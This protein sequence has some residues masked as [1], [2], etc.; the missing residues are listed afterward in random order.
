MVRENH[1]SQ[2]LNEILEEA[3]KS[4]STAI[5]M[6]KLNNGTFLEQLTSAIVQ[7]TQTSPYTEM[8]FSRGE[9]E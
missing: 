5:P 4:E 9:D 7:L 3:K 8:C 6:F 1:D 2:I